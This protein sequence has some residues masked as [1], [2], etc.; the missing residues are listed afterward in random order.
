MP[1]TALDHEDIRQLV[2]RY[3]FAV[4]LGDTEGWADCFIPEGVFLSTPE[5]GPLTGR[6]VGRE[7]LVAYAATHYRLNQGRARH[8][9]W[10]L[11][12]EGDG[13]TATMTCYLAAYSAMTEEAP[14]KLR[15]TGIYRDRLAK[16]E[17]R[18]LFAERHIHVDPQPPGSHP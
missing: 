17:D 5:G 10:N 8:W 16:V 11:L 14:P 4:D 13:A 12:V 6:H 1:M 9:N 18:W 15:V 2:A 7:A 3:N